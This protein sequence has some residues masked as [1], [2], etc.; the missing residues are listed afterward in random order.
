MFA[1]YLLIGWIVATFVALAAGCA[2]FFVVIRRETF[3]AHALPMAAF[4]G[5]AAAALFGITQIYGLIAAACF[6]TVL[7]LWFKRGQ[8]N[9]AATAL[10]LVAL[11]GLG[12]LFLSL[13][14]RYA[15]AVYALLFGQIFGL[16]SGDVAPAL[17]L[18]LLVPLVLLMA[19]R[20]LLLSALSPDLAGLRG[21]KSAA[22]NVLF[23]ALLALASAFALPV[24]GALLVF[25]LMTGPAA[26]AC[27]LVRAPG[28]AMA[29]SAGLALVLVWAA[30]A[31]SYLTAWPVGFFTGVLAAAFYLSARTWRRVRPVR[32]SPGSA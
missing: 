18:G 10:A 22:S 26:A 27:L 2:G 13:S 7:L 25:S 30:L 21:M 31:L 12:A 17:V 29:L 14:G 24:T 6:G 3:A 28:A 20:P 16:G 15:A 8:R 5:A 9:D 19:F 4:P 11:L 1:P 32:C 23:L